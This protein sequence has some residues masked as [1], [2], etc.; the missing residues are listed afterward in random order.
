[1][2]EQVIDVAKFPVRS[3]IRV[4]IQPILPVFEVEFEKLRVL[5]EIHYGILYAQRAS[6]TTKSAVHVK[7]PFLIVIQRM[8][9]DSVRNNKVIDIIVRPLQYR[10][11]YLCLS[12][13]F[14]CPAE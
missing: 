3:H 5:V 11:E 12:S 2:E 14:V 8:K 1:M 10:Q 7:P 9:S 4:R 6:H 13:A